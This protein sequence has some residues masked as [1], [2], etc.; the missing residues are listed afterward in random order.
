MKKEQEKK[1]PKIAFILLPTH[2]D[3]HIFEDNIRAIHKNFPESILLTS[4]T[5]DR[6]D[7]YEFALAPGRFDFVAKDLTNGAKLL[8]RTLSLISP[9]LFKEAN[10]IFVNTAMLRYS[11]HVFI[12]FVKK[13]IERGKGNLVLGT[14]PLLSP[15]HRANLISYLNK[16]SQD[17]RNGLLTDIFLSYILSCTNKQI[18]G[19][20]TNL[21]AGMWAMRPYYQ[22]NQCLAPSIYGINEF[23]DMN[24]LAPFLFW[25]ISSTQGKRN[26]SISVSQISVDKI[27]LDP[28]SFDLKEKI[29]EAKYIIKLLER[30]S[31][32]NLSELVGD[33]F[34]N[35]A[36]FRKIFNEDD[37]EWFNEHVLDSPQTE[38]SK[39]QKAAELRNRFK[40]NK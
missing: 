11:S 25:N 13:T 1:D 34:G 29:D 36:M 33:I 35:N 40:E 20:F 8:S 24:T 38:A 10:I 32:L 3:E 30:K 9:A 5:K 21:S 17:V 19:E 23:K 18:F 22:A 12:D 7:L 27:N 31:V 6:E 39:N 37:H 26:A 16:H 2:V 28:L 14:P 15:E 4:I